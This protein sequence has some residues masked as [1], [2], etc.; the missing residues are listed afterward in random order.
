MS[1]Q[2]IFRVFCDFY[3]FLSVLTVVFMIFRLK[4]QYF[5]QKSIFSTKNKFLILIGFFGFFLVLTV[6]F[7]IFRLK[8]STFTKKSIFSIKMRKST[9]SSIFSTF[10][11]DFC[12]FFGF[13]GFQTRLTVN[14]TVFTLQNFF[15]PK[16][17]F[18]SAKIE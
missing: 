13:Y 12:D 7:M 1:F 11:A 4:N 14:F 6:I 9:K 17:Q 3:W 15:S 2:R 5:Q 18:S 16:N 8:I 10:L